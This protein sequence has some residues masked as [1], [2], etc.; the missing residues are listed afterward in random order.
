MKRMKTKK[1]TV[2][3]E[4]TLIVAVDIGKTIHWGYFRTPGNMEIKPFP[5]HN[6]GNSFNA[7]WHNMRQFQREQGLDDIVIGF[8][9]TG[10]YAEPLIHY[11]S[12]KQVKLLQ[13]NPMHTKRLK[14][15]TG[16]SPNKSDQKDPRVIAD[17]ISL[18]HGLSVVIPQGVSAELRRLTHARERA[19]TDLTAKINQ[20]RQL[21]F[22][23]FPEFFEIMKKRVSQSALFLLK[24]YPLPENIEVL[25]LKTLTSCLQK[26]SRGRLGKQRAQEL[27]KA[28]RYSV[29]I[30]Q[31][32][33][34]I[35][36]EIKHLI[37][38]IECT[39]QFT[40]NLEA[41]MKDCLYQISYSQNILS[42][43]GVGVIISAGLI[44]EVGDF[45]AFATAKE[46]EKLA[47]L[48]LYEISSGAHKGERRISKRGRSLMRKLLYCAALNTIRIDGIMHQQYHNMLDRGM[49]KVKAV[50]AISRR[51]LK[52]IYAIVR[53]NKMFEVTH[54]SKTCLKKVA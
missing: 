4:K 53:D 54:C 25:G 18:N 37:Y 6:S 16:N 21:V 23:V 2:V 14:E 52:I 34:S 15:L 8:E 35:V 44:G 3:N 46:L 49:P 47:G 41:H 50:V 32:T 40:N 13:V 12:K 20:L 11:F 30:D 24:S 36:L 43:K 29:G 39:Q 38:Q 17:I 5:F 28:A 7:F 51:L 22:V 31:G 9:S 48:D 27:I 42:L 26:I 33:K 19:V 10:P 1:S 45:K